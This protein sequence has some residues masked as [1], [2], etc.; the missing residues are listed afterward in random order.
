MANQLFEEQEFDI[1]F[2]DINMPVMDGLALIE[3]WNKKMT[4]TQW[5]ILSGYDEFNYAQKAITLGV[6]DYLLKPVT[7][8]KAQETLVR[9]IDKYRK[10]SDHF[11]NMNELENLID[12]L[13]GAIWTLNEDTVKSSISSW[14]E[15]LVSKE[16]EVSYFFNTLNNILSMLIQRLNNRGNIV[17]EERAGI[18]NGLNIEALIDSFQQNCIELIGRIRV[19]RKG[20]VLDPIE[21]A[22]KYI[23]DNL[24]EKISLDDVADKLGLNSAYFSHLFKKETGTSF[25]EYRMQLRMEKAMRLID[26]SNMK[27]TEIANSLGY[28]DLSHFT[29]TFKKYTGLSPSKYIASLEMD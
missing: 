13:E 4:R 25:V 10:P 5:V 28:E 22:K 2:T 1:V 11:L 18:I 3:K 14:G 17:L 20:Q 12:K 8:K 21:F 27:I 6:K 7:K 29:K 16:I 19:Q 23:S 26:S 24:T 15:L 9:L